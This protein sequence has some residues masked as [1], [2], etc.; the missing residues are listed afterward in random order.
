MHTADRHRLIA[1]LLRHQETVSV[2]ELETVCGASGATIR[3]DLEVLAGQG[4]LRRTH[5]GARS[6]L[7]RGEEPGYGQRALEHRE[8]KV[9]IAA[10]ATA[11]LRDRESLV[12]DSGT[13]A[14]ELARILATRPLTVMPLSLQAIAELGGSDAVDLIL[15][16]GQP[17]AGEGAIAGP[18]AEATIRSLRFDTAVLSPCGF[19]L[20]DGA[21]AYDLGDAAIKRAAMQSSGRTILLCD[22]AKWN[23]T[24]LAVVAAADSID[25]LITDHLLTDEEADF[26]THHSVEV[27]QA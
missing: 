10:A 7:L 9:R 19:S 1:E 17:R 20:Q 14:V 11:A 21:T 3:R 6:L 2:A 25:L 5:G 27:I 13:T 8:A 26:F 12:L 24:T 22:A 18:L 16:G 23:R 4:V 15:P